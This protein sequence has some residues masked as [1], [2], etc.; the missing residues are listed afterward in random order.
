M[1]PPGA[2]FAIEIGVPVCALFVVMEM[3]ELWSLRVI[4]SASRL[5]KPELFDGKPFA[6]ILTF[7]LL[8]GDPPPGATTGV[9]AVILTLAAP[10]L[11]ITSCAVRTILAAPVCGV[12]MVFRRVVRLIWLAGE[13]LGVPPLL[14]VRK[15]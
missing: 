14:F 5:I 2:L 9:V 6:V 15:L 8:L 12:E 3:P 10:L 11:P 1:L 13:L 4:P 7:P